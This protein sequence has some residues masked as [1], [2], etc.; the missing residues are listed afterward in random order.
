MIAAVGK[1]LG[2]RENGVRVGLTLSFSEKVREV[3][4]SH[5]LLCIH[6]CSQDEVDVAYALQ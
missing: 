6:Q 4:S 1:E 2:T 3:P 5:A